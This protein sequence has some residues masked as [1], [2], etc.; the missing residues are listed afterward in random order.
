MDAIH[1]NVRQES[2]IIKKAVY[3]ALGIDMNS[4]KDIL[5]TCVDGLKGFPQAIEAAF[6]K[7]EI[8]QC[9]I[10]QIRNTTRFASYKEIKK[11]MED[12]KKVYAAPTEEAALNEL[13][14]FGEK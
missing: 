1:Y 11:V 2:R 10:H 8:Q 3:I 5:I 13:E 12:L 9:I 14:L 7:T 6:P 4:H